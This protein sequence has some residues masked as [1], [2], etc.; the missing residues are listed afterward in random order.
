MLVGGFKIQIAHDRKNTIFQWKRRYFIYFARHVSGITLIRYAQGQ[1]IRKTN[2][3]CKKWEQYKCI[4]KRPKEDSQHRQL[5]LRE[6]NISFNNNEH[7]L[8]TINYNNKYW[9]L[10]IRVLE[11]DFCADKF[12]VLTRRN[13]NSHHR[14][15]A[16]LIA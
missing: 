4:S 14:Y 12:L 16:T 15:T 2:K 7:Y 3:F 6:E 10:L 5:W 13:S 8:G 1:Q 11:L 9:K